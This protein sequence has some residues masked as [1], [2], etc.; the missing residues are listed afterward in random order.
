[1]IPLR[2]RTRR[3]ASSGDALATLL[4]G[5]TRSLRSGASF[6]TAF[7]ESVIDAGVDAT[8]V[9]RAVAVSLRRGDP[10]DDVLQAWAATAS[11]DGEPHDVHVVAA[12]LRLQLRCGGVS[13]DAVERLAT[14]VR[15]RL[16]AAASARVEASQA[17][18]SARVLG[19]APVVFAALVVA[20]DGDV[21]AFLL[22]SWA[23]RCC[24]AA[25]AVLDVMAFVVMRRIVAGV[26]A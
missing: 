17:R 11:T 7:A 4:D 15:L 14:L 23:G 12:A 10:A 16:D 5:L 2:H 21:R 6:P 24:L 9:M 18:A 8:P 25:A 3:A 22:L 13:A 1:M 26:A 19:G 20:G